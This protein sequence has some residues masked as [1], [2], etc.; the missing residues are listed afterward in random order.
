MMQVE[1]KSVASPDAEEVK[2]TLQPT[3]PSSVEQSTMGSEKEFMGRTVAEWLAAM[4]ALGSVVM[5]VFGCLYFSDCPG[6]PSLPTYALAFGS[7]SILNGAIPLVFRIEKTKAAGSDGG[8]V[9]RV[10]ELIGLCI[11][12]CATWGAAITWGET[13]RFGDSPGCKKQLYIT[14]FISSSMA[15]GIVT[16]MFLGFL[17]TAVMKRFESKSGKTATGGVEQSEP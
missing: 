15:L 10:V 3:A 7:L 9:E 13:R 12:G 4:P 14:G 1:T 6:I 11:I 8:A 17:G 16:I 5:I 2:D